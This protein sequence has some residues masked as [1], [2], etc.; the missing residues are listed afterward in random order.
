VS[1]P[2]VVAVCVVVVGA[3]GGQGDAPDVS[4]SVPVLL[5]SI[6]RLIASL[7]AVAS[8]VSFPDD[9]AVSELQVVPP[10]ALVLVLVTT[11]VVA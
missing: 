11:S 4:E 6:E 2:E 1:K 9:E 7:D 8:M 3:A 5:Y 10:L